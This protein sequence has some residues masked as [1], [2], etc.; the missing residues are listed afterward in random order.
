MGQTG[1]ARFVEPL[2][3][4]LWTE[5]AESVKLAILTS[6]ESLVPEENQ[7]R[8]PTGLAAPPSIDDKI[9]LWTAWWAAARDPRR[10]SL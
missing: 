4:M 10:R 8:Q 7:P 5:P 1:Q 6:L 3:K 2:L 9:R